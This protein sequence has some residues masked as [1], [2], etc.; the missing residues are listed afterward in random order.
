MHKNIPNVI[1]MQWVYSWCTKIFLSLEIWWENHW[2][3]KYSFVVVYDGCTEYAKYVEN[4]M[5]RDFVIM[6]EIWEIFIGDV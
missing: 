1:G 6:I 4:S 3:T 2:C 5:V